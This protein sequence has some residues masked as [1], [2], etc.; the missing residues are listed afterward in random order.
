MPLFKCENC[1]CIENTALG[2]YWSKSMKDF[3]GTEWEKAL[4]SECTPDTFPDGTSCD[5]G[6]KWH[7][8]FPK[9]QATE[10]DKGTL[11]NY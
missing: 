10:K 11:I 3:K 6:G 1:G 2:H 4:C 7:G 5:K 9:E 8:I